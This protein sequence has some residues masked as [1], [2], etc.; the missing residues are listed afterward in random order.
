MDP[1]VK[2]T[3]EFAAR[4]FDVT[5]LG[6]NREDMSS[7]PV[8][9]IDGY[10][11]ERLQRLDMAPRQYLDHLNLILSKPLATFARLLGP[12]AA[13][14]EVLDGGARW[15][16]ERVPWRFE[17]DWARSFARRLLRRRLS[18]EGSPSGTKAVPEDVE[19]ASE[20]R[21]L[22]TR[23]HYISGL[24][25]MQFS[26]ATQLFWTY[27]QQIERKPDVVHCNDLDTLL[28]GALAKRFFGCRVVYD[29][30]EYYPYADP[31]GRWLDIKFF[32]L[33]ESLLLRH[34]DGAVTVNPPLAAI[35]S[36]A[37]GRPDIYSVPNAEPRAD[38]AV[39][40]FVSAMTELGAGRL[41]CL[42]QGRYSPKRGTEEIILGWK[43]VDPSKAALFLR[44]PNNV[45]TEK[46][47]ELARSLGLLDTSVYF[48]DS[49]TEDLLVPAA[50]EADV[51]II[52]YLP[53]FLIY[54]FSCP[55]K[56]SQ[57]MHAG[58][59]VL[60]ND[61]PYVRSVVED[62]GAGLV[63]NSNRPE[64]VGEAVNKVAN[65]PGL[66]AAFKAH[67]RHYARET[68]N[69]QAY[70][71]IFDALYRGEEPSLAGATTEAFPPHAAALR[72]TG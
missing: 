45:Y 26:P 14:I 44:G 72:P 20:M 58:L 9:E 36:K 34:V 33:L 24:L 51:G 37:Y 49:V 46:A 66:L 39:Q 52:P 43:Y 63:Y 10:R 42:F 70:F 13:S 55:N 64:S 40:P 62:A 53:E 57:Y 15:L 17:R 12:A 38:T 48:L 54:Q 11:V 27:I 59:M 71:G 67:G 30:H 32:A 7:A 1:R 47:K 35:M 4:D 6:F 68:F 23:A 60:T 19:F 28:V 25:R 18:V 50:A 56:L 31:Y 5:V 2:W 65:D 41:K 61:L 69:W 21:R 29:A 8:E 3:A 22:R 16:T